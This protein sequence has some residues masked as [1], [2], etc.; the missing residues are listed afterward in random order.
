MS[1]DWGGEGGAKVASENVHSFV[2]YFVLTASLIC[3][4]Y[5]P[6]TCHAFSDDKV[7]AIDCMYYETYLQQN[8]SKIARHMHRAFGEMVATRLV[9]DF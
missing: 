6:N 3:S 9:L 7:P 5:S 8:S 4:Q 2:T 1:V